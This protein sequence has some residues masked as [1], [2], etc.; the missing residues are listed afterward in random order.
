[1]STKKKPQPDRIEPVKTSKPVLR[2]SFCNSEQRHVEKLI[3]GPNV[4]I[5]SSCTYIC[6]DILHPG[7]WPVVTALA[8]RHRHPPECSAPDHGHPVPAVDEP[9]AG[10][11]QP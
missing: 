5:C 1:M 4:H 2:C 8:S 7:L 11:V 10:E 6:M 3:A 9:P